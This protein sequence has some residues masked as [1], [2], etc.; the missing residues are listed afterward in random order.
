MFTL[1]GVGFYSDMTAW[2]LACVFI[3]ANT[4]QIITL[5]L[6]TMKQKF[7][8]TLITLLGCVN[9]VL[10]KDYAIDMSKAMSIT[11]NDLDKTNFTTKGQ[12][13][14]VTSAVVDGKYFTATFN[15][16]TA[17]GWTESRNDWVANP[18]GKAI[19]FN[20]RAQLKKR[21]TVT[22]KFSCRGIFTFTAMVILLIHSN[23]LV[24]KTKLSI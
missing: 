4:I 9:A 3:A 13:Y 23:S 22:L 24:W 14:S 16:E 18:E 7:L 1:Q 20:Q 8:L 15:N 2:C 11:V 21:T 5:K 10:A 12:P 6:K 19:N 17:G